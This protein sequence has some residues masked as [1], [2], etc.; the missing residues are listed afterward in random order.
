[1]HNNKY[2]EEGRHL[3]YP[4]YCDMFVWNKSEKKWTKRKNNT[5]VSRM[6]FVSPIEGERY[7]LRMLLTQIKGAT[8]YEDLRTF[9]NH[10]YS[11]FKEACTSRGLLEDDNEWNLCLSEASEIQT[12]YELRQLFALILSTCD[13]TYPLKLWDKHKQALSEDIL[14]K[15]R[16][17]LNNNNYP[18]DS[19]IENACLNEIEKILLTNNKSLKM[20]PEFN[21]FMPTCINDCYAEEL[22][23][24]T[25]KQK[26]NAKKNSSSLTSEQKKTFNDIL[27]ELKS[28]K[29]KSKLFFI[30]GFGG[31]GK[32]YFYN[33][34]LPQIRGDCVFTI[35]RWKNC[36]L[37]SKNS[38]QM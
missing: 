34:L 19:Y 10:V 13:V 25:K 28:D 1:M 37:Q 17:R 22:Q 14:Y 11:T 21:F 18:Y 16:I 32:T 12:G 6:V 38:T 33:T 2:I 20:F 4:D 31:S 23:Y 9:N 27:K 15:E 5:A 35:R 30:D 26:T 3:I 24:C 29:L 7:Y 36:S 8:C